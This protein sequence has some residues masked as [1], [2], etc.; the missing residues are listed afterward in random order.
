[1]HQCIEK[2]REAF[3][4]GTRSID[5]VRPARELGISR[6]TLYRLIDKHGRVH[7]VE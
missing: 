3:F 5:K 2:Q 7:R 4:L 1:M 6:M